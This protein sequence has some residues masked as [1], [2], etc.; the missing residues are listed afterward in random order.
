MTLISSLYKNELNR[1]KPINK[2]KVEKKPKIILFHSSQTNSQ[3]QFHAFFGEPK[4]EKVGL[5]SP[6]I[7]PALNR[8]KIIIA[9]TANFF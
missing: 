9:Q 6:F 8:S 3:F 4:W 5:V 1:K 2:R 7:W